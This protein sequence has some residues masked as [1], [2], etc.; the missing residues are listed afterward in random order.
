MTTQIVGYLV[1][2]LVAA[3]VLKNRERLGFAAGGK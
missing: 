3:A 1:A 2:G